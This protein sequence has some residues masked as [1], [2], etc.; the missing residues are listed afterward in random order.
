[1]DQQAVPGT[2][3]VVISCRQPLH[4]RYDPQVTITSNEI[5][6]TVLAKQP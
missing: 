2:Y 6:V 5:A 4:E 3:D 1:M